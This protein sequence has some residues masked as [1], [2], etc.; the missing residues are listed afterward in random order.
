MARR[1]EEGD[2]PAAVLDAPGADDLGDAPRLGGGHVALAD[3]VQQTGFAVVDVA[4]DGHDR[5]ARNE[6]LRLVRL[7]E[8]VLFEDILFRVE[9]ML[10]F[11]LA[12]VFQ[13]DDLGHFRINGGV[14]RHAP[15]SRDP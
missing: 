2:R 12:A 11:Q 14:D 3:P 15:W 8:A 1:I 6:V 7:V 4:H 10:D 9:R 13:G 5:S